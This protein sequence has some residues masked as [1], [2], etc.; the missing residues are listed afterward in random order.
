MEFNEIKP[1]EFGEKA[2]AIKRKK[3]EY[4]RK[5]AYICDQIVALHKDFIHEFGVIGKYSGD[6]YAINATWSFTIKE[7][8]MWRRFT[9]WLR[10]FL[11]DSPNKDEG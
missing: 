11:N 2:K 10:K 6:F 3:A 8:T 5:L 9:I 1:G 7:H 4:D